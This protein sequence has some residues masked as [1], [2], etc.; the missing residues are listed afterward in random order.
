ML[1]LIILSFPSPLGGERE[2]TGDISST[3]SVMTS[4]PLS[5][6]QSSAVLLLLLLLAV[7]A[8][9]AEGTGITLLPAGRRKC[10]LYKLSQA[11]KLC[12]RCVQTHARADDGRRA[13]HRRSARDASKCFQVQQWLKGETGISATLSKCTRISKYGKMHAGGLVLSYR[14]CVHACCGPS[15][16]SYSLFLWWGCCGCL[17]S[18][19]ASW[20]EVLLLWPLF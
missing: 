1:S 13:A 7:V 17:R 15:V 9:V 3:R 20:R 5:L 18:L 8:A 16:Y 10:H 12:R 2:A 4:S 6:P 14:H 11:K 19:Q